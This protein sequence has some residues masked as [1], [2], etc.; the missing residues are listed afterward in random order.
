MYQE[1]AR[2]IP[3]TTSL[4][5]LDLLDLEV[6]ELCRGDLTAIVGGDPKPDQQFLSETGQ[7]DLIAG[8]EGFPAVGGPRRCYLVPHTLQPDGDRGLQVGVRDL[9]GAGIRG[10]RVGICSILE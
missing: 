3:P 10:V 2:G 4:N 5:R 9:P 8:L 1:V 7:F 6:P